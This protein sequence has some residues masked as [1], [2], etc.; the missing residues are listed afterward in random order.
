MRTL[1][2][3]GEGL[4]GEDLPCFKLKVAVVADEK[5]KKK[6]QDLTI[7]MVKDG[8]SKIDQLLNP[9]GA[10]ATAF[11]LELPE[12]KGRLYVQAVHG[13]TPS[14]VPLFSGLIDAQKLGKIS[15]L[16]AALITKVGGRYF[17][18]TFGNGRHLVG[19]DIF[20]ERF[21]LLVVLNSV[22][23]N[24]IRVVDK[25]S[26][27]AIQSHAR[28][29]SG[30]ETSADQFGLDVEQDMLK[31]IVGSPGSE[32]L[33]HRMAG[34]E[35]LA[36]SVRMDLS[37]LAAL[38]KRYK[39]RFEADLDPDYA[40]VNNIK[41]VRKVSP[42][43]AALDKLLVEKLN[44]EDDDRIWLSIPEVIDWQSVA[45][46]RFTYGGGVRYPDISLK[47]FLDSLGDNERI[48]LQ[49]LH[50]R[51]VICADADNQPLRKK[52]SVYRCVYAEID[53][54][55][56]K[57]VLNSGSWFRVGA[58]FV[59]T[60][61]TQFASAKYSKLK[62]PEYI[63]GDEGKYNKDVADKQPTVFALLDNKNKIFH[64]GGKGQVEACDLLSVD[65][66]LIHIKRYGKSSVLSHLFA[67]GFVSGQAIQ[68]DSEFRKKLKA[69]L[70][71]PFAELINVP[72]RPADKEFTVVFAV[73]SNVP[74]AKLDLPF[75][76]RVNFNNTAKVLRG[77]GYEVELL[78]IDW[79]ENYA[80]TVTAAPGRKKKLV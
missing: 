59:A 32:L 34:S 30:Q 31:A 25:Q 29:Q 44:N 42:A 51:D 56:E 73:I 39:E 76:S 63:G 80:K 18:L 28:I 49:L 54:N 26:L 2:I 10:K 68:L 37:D 69:K 14:W 38:L 43:V 17:V 66:Q 74:G 6:V 67:Q 12:C 77:F 75:F 46:F 15:T 60:T 50:D 41:E 47:G 70:K 11:D 5:P 62:L 4:S 20:E 24:S 7:Y 19:N 21:G 16:S 1:S 33:G 23:P 35:A 79:D 52:W 55:G 48:T 8:F 72:P 13:I 40:W 64:G 36:V 65:K 78:K 53:H 27:D 57:Y 61:N 45:G 58:D 3:L 71:S 9:K 22:N